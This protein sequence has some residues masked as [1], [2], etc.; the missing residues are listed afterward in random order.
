MSDELKK[1]AQACSNNPSATRPPDISA[2]IHAGCRH[3]G[4]RSR[5]PRPPFRSVM[6]SRC[7][8]GKAEAGCRGQLIKLRSLLAACESASDNASCREVIE[9]LRNPYYIGDQPGA[10]QTS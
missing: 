2:E 8:L 6:A 9:N 7:K 4:K 10:T 3:I 5:S 1:C